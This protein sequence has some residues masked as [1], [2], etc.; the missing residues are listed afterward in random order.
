MCSTDVKNVYAFMG[1]SINGHSL[2]SSTYHGIGIAYS[3]MGNSK[4]ALEYLE[5][6]LE[7]SKRIFN[8][9]YSNLAAIF[10]DIGY[11]YRGV[12]LLK[13]AQENITN[14]LDMNER[15][16]L[17]EHLNLVDSYEKY[18]L[19]LLDMG[20]REQALHY[21]TKAVEMGEK[22]FDVE[23][24]KLTQIYHIAGSVYMKLRDSEKH[25]TI[26]TR[27]SKWLGNNLRVTIWN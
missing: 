10:G 1:R 2:L 23:H 26:L 5:K 14:G 11:L 8:G 12:G 24:P 4:K 6:C 25:W 9:V 22:L 27:D 13:K 16:F 3:K 18:S 19:L 7:M 21:S 20:N 15:L 17:T